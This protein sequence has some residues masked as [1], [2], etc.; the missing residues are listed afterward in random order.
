[1]FENATIDKF[2]IF[3]AFVLVVWRQTLFFF[4]FWTKRVCTWRKSLA[5]AHIFHPLIISSRPGGYSINTEANLISNCL[6][7]KFLWDE[8]GWVLV[9]SSEPQPVAFSKLVDGLLHLV[10]DG[11]VV[12]GDVEGDGARR[13]EDEGLEQSLCLQ[14]QPASLLLEV[15]CLSVGQPQHQHRG[16]IALH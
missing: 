6:K 3:G 2:K 11:V 14:E 15:F 9:F 4:K 1:M 16:S 10:D 13:E 5:V 12:V 7:T 8:M